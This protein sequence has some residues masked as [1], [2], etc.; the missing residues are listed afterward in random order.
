M[1][2]HDINTIPLLL[3]S[4]QPT[5]LPWI[6]MSDD[7]GADSSS[8]FPFSARTNRQTNRR[9]WTP[10]PTPAAIQPAWGISSL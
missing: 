5:N 6:I 9:D 2:K 4:N 3:N 1:I 8:R 10:Y 7:L